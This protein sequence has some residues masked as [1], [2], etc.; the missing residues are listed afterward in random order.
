MDY[1]DNYVIV[2]GRQYASGGRRIGK[3]LADQLGIAYYDKALLAKAA[4]LMGFSAGLF[5]NADEKRPSMLRSLLQLN[6]G[7]PNTGYPGSGLSNESLYSYQSEVIRKICEQGS[8]VIVGRTADYVMREHPRMISI[9]VHSPIE[10]RV[11]HMLESGECT[12]AD[13]AADKAHKIDRE[14]ESYYNYYTNRHWG[15]SDN[16]HLSI[17]S[18]RVSKE[19]L[20]QMVK[21]ILNKTD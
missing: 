15:R 10:A 6:Y 13:K 4:E 7:E 8:C 17:D 5:A 11:Q 1:Q 12:N 3:W 16:Y 20:L 9:F 19:A 2:I 14:R 18:T 21:D